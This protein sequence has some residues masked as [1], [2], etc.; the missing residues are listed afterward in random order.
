MAGNDD[1]LVQ[2]TDETV[3]ADVQKILDANDETPPAPPADPLN[4]SDPSKTTVQK[5]K[6]VIDG[7]EEELTSDQIAEMKKGNM[8]HKDYTQKTQEISKMREELDK[9]KAE[10]KDLYEVKEHINQHPEKGAKIRAILDDISEVQNEINRGGTEN[11]DVLTEIKKIRDEILSVKQAADTK[12]SDIALD[13]EVAEL[14]KKYPEFNAKLRRET[15]KYADLHDLTNLEEAYSKLKKENE[16]TREEMR[17]ELRKELEAE[18]LKQTESF[19]NG[20]G[21]VNADYNPLKKSDQDV[22]NEA[23]RRVS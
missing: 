1:M 21:T 10:L 4:P 19:T 9:Q 2:E 18:K 6:V 20:S 13:T 16:Q 15:L 14:Y 17:A 22:L 3:S 7:K 23:L 12:Q 8:L 11:S 5:F